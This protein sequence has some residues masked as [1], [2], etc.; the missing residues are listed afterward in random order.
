MKRIIILKDVL[1]ATNGSAAITS[2]N[3]VNTLAPGALAIFTEDG[4]LVDP[5]GIATDLLDKK[6]VCFAV[7]G[8]D[9]AGVAQATCTPYYDRWNNVNVV[10]KAY[11]APVKPQVLVGDDGTAFGTPAVSLNMPTLTGS[12]QIAGIKIIDESAGTQPPIQ[13]KTYETAVKS[14]D[15]A[16]LINARL[17]AKINA[18]ADAFV[19]AT[20]PSTT[21]V[22]LLITPKL[23]GI[24]ISVA[25][26]GVLDSASITYDGTGA[27]TVI[28]YGTGT[29]AMIEAIWQQLSTVLGNTNK[30]ELPAYF[31]TAT[32]GVDLAATY[33]MYWI[34]TEVL[35]ETPSGNTTAGTPELII[36]MPAGAATLTQANFDIMLAE[37][38]GANRIKYEVGT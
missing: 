13:Y 19:V 22:G 21:N 9:A 17:V 18:D 34:K 33:D 14:G 16:A 35:H 25:T 6:R 26:Y 2:I 12:P 24:K 11:V 1:Y 37:I 5:V 3:N 31:F 30:V 36:A 23:F 15:T 20:D 8:V 4:N 10:K 29:P 27:S 32:S 38:F 28:V 7:G